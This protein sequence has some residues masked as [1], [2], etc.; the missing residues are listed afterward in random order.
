MNSATNK[1]GYLHR[2]F[3]RWVTEHDGK[4][5]LL[6]TAWEVC[7]RRKFDNISMGTYETID[8]AEAICK[9]LNSIE[10]EDDG[11]SK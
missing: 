4:G 2:Y 3:T 7:D 1:K 5:G 9:L 10:E 11:L 6:L 8:K